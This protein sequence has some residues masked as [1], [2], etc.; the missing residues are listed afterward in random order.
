MLLKLALLEILVRIALA[1][2][3]SLL[4]KI[5]SNVL[6]KDEA[7]ALISEYSEAGITV[8][9]TYVPPGKAPP[10]G[11]RKLYLAIGMITYNFLNITS[12][13]YIKA[14]YRVAVSL[15]PVEPSVSISKMLSLSFCY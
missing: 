10:E 2:I 13:G 12:L 8:R 9:G 14:S 6:Q 4:N 15:Q 7:L 1:I 5:P 11:E 3:S